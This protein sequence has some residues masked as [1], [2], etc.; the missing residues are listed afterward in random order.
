MTKN[1]N[2]DDALLK[3]FSYE[4]SRSYESVF[5]LDLEILRTN[6]LI[7]YHFISNI[8]FC[9]YGIVQGLNLPK[10]KSNTT[11]LSNSKVKVLLL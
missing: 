9:V 7:Y 6:G 8:K 2:L 1:F 5:I 4:I 3:L 11:A 10:I